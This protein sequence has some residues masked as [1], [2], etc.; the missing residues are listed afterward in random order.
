MEIRIRTVASN[1]SHVKRALR[2]LRSAWC[3]VNG[4]HYKVL[5][6]E[7]SRMALRCVACGRTSPGVTI[8]S[9]TMGRALPA[10]PERLR[11]VVR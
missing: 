6:T 10:I 5:H 3:V 11:A 1:V 7:P 9:S 2:F 4:G 8:G